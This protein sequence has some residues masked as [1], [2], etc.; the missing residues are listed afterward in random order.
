M[1]PA[2]KTYLDMKYDAATRLG[3]KWA[4]YTSVRDS[5]EWDPA[6]LLAGVG[7][8]PCSASRRRSGRRR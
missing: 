3:L 5:Y 7:E 1:S 6:T 8:R 4:G 2:A